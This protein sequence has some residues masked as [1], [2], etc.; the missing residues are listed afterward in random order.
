MTTRSITDEQHAR[1]CRVEAICAAA[2]RVE[3]DLPVDRAAFLTHYYAQAD[4]EEIARDP[5]MLARAALGHLAWARTR[6]PGN[7]MLRVFNP[8]RERDGWTSEHTIVETANDDMPFLVDSL[9]MTLTGLNQPIHVTIHPLLQLERTAKGELVS[10]R[11][12]RNGGPDGKSTTESFIHVEIVRETDASILATIEAALSSTLRAVRTCVE[13]WPTMLER[14]RAAASDLRATGGLPQD[15][16]AESGAFLE[17]LARDHFT[18]L[19]YREYELVRGAAFDELKPRAGTGLGLLRG[20]GN[21]PIARLAGR[22][23]EEARSEN[24]LVI[25]KSSERSPVH[26]SAPLDHIG[27]K[28]FDDSGKPVMEHRFLGL[29]TSV[30]YH[31]SPRTIP[32]LRLKI[33]RLM[34]QSGLDPLSHRGKSLQHI[35]DTLPR[36]DLFQASLEDLRVIS[37][38][39]LGLEARHKLKLFVRRET[40]GRFYS[41]LV[42]LPRD[43][44]NSRARRAIETILL[45]GL[46]GNAVESELTIA[47]SALARLAVTVRTTPAQQAE[48]DVAALQHELENTVRTWQD[49]LRE[50]LLSQLPEDRALDLLHRFGEHFSAAYQDEADAAR[51]G[52]DIQKLAL[53]DEHAS[54]LEIALVRSASARP[55]RLRLTSIKRDEPIQLYVALPVLENLGFKVISERVY[56]VHRNANQLW[57]Q[58]FELET[59]NKQELD[60]AAV[61]ER[62]K[63]IFGLV[64]RGDAENDSFNSFVVSAGLDWRQAVLLRAFCKYILQTG[65][66]YSQAYMQGVLARYPAYCRALVDK[67]AGLFD[68]ERS[69]AQRGALLAAS[70]N[71]IK[72]ELDRTVSLDDDR[73]LRAF[74]AVVNAILR[75]NYYQFTK[76]ATAKPGADGAGDSANAPKPYI[77]FKLDPSLLPDLPKPRPK[78]EIFVYSQRVEGVHLRSSKI[79]RGGIR[80]SD[81][82]EDFRTEVLGLMKAQQVKNTVIVPNGA[83]GGFVCKQLPAGDREGVQR[84]VVACYQTF[85]RGLLDVTDNIVDGKVVPPQRVIRKD[86]DDPYLVV[87]ADKG[88]ATFSDIANALS[89]EYSHWLGDAFASGGSAGYDHKKMAITA[90]G[91]W[92]AVKRH[93][94]ELGVDPHAQDFTVIGIGDMSGDVFG[95]GMLLSPQ[96]KLVAAFDHR[97]IFIDPSPDPAA[98]IAERRRLFELPRSSWD[99]YDRKRLSEGGG[100]YSRQTKAIEL[101]P[102]AQALLDL[103]AA[104]VTPLELIRA[105]LKAR[106]DLFWNG[107]IGTYVKASTESHLDAGDPVNDAVRVDGGDLRCRIVAEGGNLGF[108]QRGRVEYALGGGKIN[109]DFIDNSGG[110]DSSDREVNIKILLEDVI[111]QKKLPRSQR[112]ALLAEM[113]DQIAALVLNSNYQQTQAL[114]M[115]DSRA[116][117]RLGEHARL[118][119]VL[120]NQGLLDRA[121]EFLPTEEQI[122]ER[123]ASGHGL[124][125]P[126]LAII[127]SYSK[128]EL[129]GSLL[130]T[131]IPEDPYLAAELEL[132]F[133]RELSERFKAQIRQHRLRREIIAMLVGGSMIN[134]MGPFF[135]LRAEEETGANVAQVARAYAIVREV[136]SIRKLWREIEL[137]DHKVDAKVQYDAIFQIS[138]MVRRAVY[139]LLQN[140]AQQLDVESMVKRFQPGVGDAVAALPKLV[141]GRSDPRYVKDAQQ[142]ESVGLPP[143]LARQIAALSLMTQMFDVI[144]LAREFRLSVPEVGQLY[145]ALAKELRLDV[146]REQIEALP[147]EGRWRAMARATLRETLAQEQRGLLRS[148]LAAGSSSAGEGD[149]LATWLDKRRYDIARVQ[150][151]LDDMLMSGALD[152]ATLSVALKEVGRLV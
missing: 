72:L 99:D 9:G 147:V 123:R 75:T 126:E 73:I 30:A 12:A 49:R 23:R 125:R 16:K 149:A 36:D 68:V 78:Y 39:V 128:I 106:V 81:R 18:L 90:R 43:Q 146:L 56:P 71:V 95:N 127:L 52:V 120:E 32:L 69:P 82:R 53:I 7:A 63:Q 109:T 152:F 66:R 70:E 93:F 144:E 45:T 112:N 50:A 151:G 65:L 89:A 97:H 115:M 131:D 80:W 136:F 60:P 105:V 20:D 41:C 138:R 117:E 58:D 76:P 19:G 110:V 24:P 11:Y 27:I 31:H 1:Q 130:Q 135:V 84:E 3:L 103:P 2:E 5:D 116:A 37:S 118:I 148:A 44:Y 111:R 21:E 54:E 33:R 142:L 34:D 108:T 14:L 67:F 61:D 101:H 4:M 139:W 129:H 134:R 122:E 62:F 133:P 121:L 8:T 57:I 55:G 51:A 104:T 141:T 98:S 17:W 74:G 132:Y 28:V 38:G 42:Y 86:E 87:A 40:F 124:T 83:K 25:T 143:D 79:A 64:L 145:F 92:E 96:I 48:P 137:L 85:I 91:A 6:K 114:S 22:A 35:L 46:G 15:L 59:A 150:R 26:R 100:I 119:R 29:F 102:A 140:Y 94:R 47:D 13:D 10:A 88:T 77:S 113:T 107:G